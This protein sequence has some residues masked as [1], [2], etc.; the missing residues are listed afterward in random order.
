MS[1]PPSSPESLLLQRLEPLGRVV[2]L[3]P[4]EWLFRQGTR[5]E[6]L[7]YVIQGEV[8]LHRVSEAGKEVVLQRATRGFVAEASW[9]VPRYHCDAQALRATRL[10][11]VRLEEFRR[12]LEQDAEFRQSW[13]R[14][15]STEIRR[16]RSRCER[17]SMPALE[18]RLFHLI[19]TEGHQGRL[20]W[21]ASWKELARELGV[22]HEAFYR[23][24]S[25]LASQG[26]LKRQE[27]VL[28]VEET[29]SLGH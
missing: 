18:D 26:R 25:Q 9:D 14:H 17:L 19:E 2:D 15:L 6:S 8:S 24:L 16:L 5:P 7:Y 12:L 11:R 4:L 20:E 10:V 3:Q 22:S 27:Q 13:M 1:P 28:S 23:K 21:K 29:S